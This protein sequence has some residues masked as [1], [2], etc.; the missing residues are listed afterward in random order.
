MDVSSSGVPGLFWIE[1]HR[2]A[3]MGRHVM[4]FIADYRPMRG[5]FNEF[6]FPR[7]SSVLVSA[8]IIT[9]WAIMPPDAKI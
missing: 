1:D 6:R 7:M 4:N 2:A 5:I 9:P 8:A 3:D